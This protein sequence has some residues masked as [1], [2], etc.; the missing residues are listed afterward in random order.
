MSPSEK[1]LSLYNFC[2]SITKSDY[3]HPKVRLLRSV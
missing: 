2:D 3:S 1:R